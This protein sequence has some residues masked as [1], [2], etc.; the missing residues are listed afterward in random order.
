M[1]AQKKTAKD[2]LKSFQFPCTGWTVKKEEGTWML[3]NRNKQINALAL[4]E[5]ESVK[6]GPGEWQIYGNKMKGQFLWQGKAFKDLFGGIACHQYYQDNCD[7]VP[8]QAPSEKET[9][10]VASLAK[11]EKKIKDKIGVLQ[12]EVKDLGEA[13]LVDLVN[14]MSRKGSLNKTVRTVSGEEAGWGYVMCP[15]D[16][17]LPLFFGF[18]FVLFLSIHSSQLVEFRIQILFHMIR[19]GAPTTD[20]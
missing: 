16:Q 18:G 6:N 12:Q 2:A 15:L 7:E 10:R 20:L 8:E 9:E 3:N 1:T 13:L 11:S 14:L 5:P 17:C 4:P 19:I